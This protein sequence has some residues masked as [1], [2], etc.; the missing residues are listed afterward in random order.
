MN[1]FIN[2]PIITIGFVAV[3]I[4]AVLMIV[5]VNA[6]ERIVQLE[7]MLRQMRVSFENLDEQAKLIVKT[8]L[9]L[10]R[11]QETLDKKVKSL[12]A[13]QRISRLIST[14]LNEEEIFHRLSRCINADLDFQKHLIVIFDQRKQPVFRSSQGY[15]DADLQ[16][17]RDTFEKNKA[18]I[19]PLLEGRGCSSTKP[20]DTDP[21]PLMRLFDVEH[22]VVAPLLTQNGVVGIIF[23][24]NQS[25]ILSDGDEE[26]VAILANQLG[27]SLENARLFEEIFKGRQALESKVQE[28]TRELEQALKEVQ[29]ISKKKSTFIS[30]VSHELRTP[31]TSIKGY[32]SILI[33]GKLGDVPDA[34]KQR[35]EKINIHSD[36]LVAMIN[37]LLD[38]ARIESGRV[39]MN[40]QP[41]A[42]KKLIDS[43]EDI[44]GPQLKNK[45]LHFIKDIGGNIPETILADEHQIERV[46][47]NLIGN[48]V[49]FTPPQGTITVKAHAQDNAVVFNIS[50]TGIGMS[51]QDM[52]HLFEEFYRVENEINQTAT[53]TGLGLA[54][55]KKIVEA[56]RG[57][58]QVASQAGSGTTFS[59]TI[60]FK[61]AT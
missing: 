42:V 19:K 44:L 58:I 7:K 40:C 52:Q 48:A 27:Q 15:T 18:L 59:F 47:I 25:Q 34:V 17:I 10:N 49:K 32:A 54:L 45:Q 8:D 22:F 20:S 30:A 61:T 55:V 31:L 57:K 21:F 43:A 12:D 46:F 50:D 28:R 2:D 53:G 13:L 35:L 14:T 26:L 24:G 16:L 36:N 11:T 37:N 29:V 39:E 4:I 60:P 6:S 1:T 23:A 51:E 5:L 3:V 41:V 38:I 56:H 33:A 9:E